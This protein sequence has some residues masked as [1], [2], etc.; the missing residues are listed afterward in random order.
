ML[1]TQ[2]RNYRCHGVVRDLMTALEDIN[3]LVLAHRFHASEP[4]VISPLAQPLDM[5]F[6][7]VVVVGDSIDVFNEEPPGAPTD[8]LVCYSTGNVSSVLGRIVENR[9]REGKPTIAMVAQVDEAQAR[10]ALAEDLAA[11]IHMKYQSECETAEP[12]NRS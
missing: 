4:T 3:A 6:P 9:R 11:R 10:R 8:A 1:A 12:G 5:D 2:G 7:G